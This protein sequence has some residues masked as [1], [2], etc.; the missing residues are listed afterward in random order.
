MWTFAIPPDVIK[1]RLQGSPDGTYK[2]FIDCAVKTVRADG[3]KAL[4]KGFAPAM[5]RVSAAFVGRTSGEWGWL[6]TGLLFLFL[7]LR[8]T[9]IPCERGVLRES[10]WLWG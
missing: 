10:T 2:G 6:L 5:A 3:P 7:L 8:M 1:S 9:G 4:F